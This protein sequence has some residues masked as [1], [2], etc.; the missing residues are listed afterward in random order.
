MIIGQSNMAGRGSLS[1]ASP[2]K[3]E[4]KR[5]KVLRNG[6]WQNIFRPVNPDRSFSGTC[7][8]ESFARA[9][10]DEHEGVNV[11][12]IPCADGGTKIDQWEKGSLLFENALFN[13]K[14]AM[15]T[16]EL[17]AILWHQGESDCADELCGAYYDKLCT[18]MK[19]LRDELDAHNI[20][21]VVGEL[22]YYLINSQIA[23]AENYPRINEAL[24]RFADNTPL[25]ACV[26]AE[27]L[28][29]KDDNL[30]FNAA[31]LDVFGLRYYEAFKSLEDKERV[32]KSSY[33]TDDT[34]R[35][36]IEQL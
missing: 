30:H 34:K 18:M 36:A 26:S 16:S 35:S 5:L 29:P 17:V 25:C 21:L 2:L 9:Y 19:A 11:G 31:S 13:A 23:G 6:R 12:I 33:D 15:R 27:G 32:F 22:G 4:D 10:A 7:L 1:E 24:H 20:P 8:A 14:Q 28:E 3:N